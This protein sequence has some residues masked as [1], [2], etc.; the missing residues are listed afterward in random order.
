ME[1]AQIGRASNWERRSRTVC[2]PFIIRPRIYTDSHTHD[3]LQNVRN[4]MYTSWRSAWWANQSN[5]HLLYV[6]CTEGQ[7][8]AK[9]EQHSQAMY[10][11][12]TIVPRFFASAGWLVD[13]ARHKHLP[14]PGCGHR[15]GPA[16]RWILLGNWRTGCIRR[17]CR[18]LPGKK[19]DLA[20][21]YSTKTIL[22]IFLIGNNINRIFEENFNYVLYCKA[23]KKSLGLRALLN[24]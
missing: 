23:F 14:Q 10:K 2:Q 24:L 4:S 20:K 15:S 11:I 16:H 5:I 9:Q 7:R 12:C 17:Q 1:S 19:Q 6:T 8:W 22:R 18:S 13:W 3:H 21:I